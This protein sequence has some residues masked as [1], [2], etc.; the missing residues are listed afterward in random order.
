ML[1]TKE[2]LH[3]EIINSVSLIC[4]LESHARLLKMFNVTTPMYNVVIH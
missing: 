3:S 4:A 2:L 1:G